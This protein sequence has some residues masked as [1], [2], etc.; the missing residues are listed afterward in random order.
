LERFSVWKS[1][2]TQ[3]GI[4]ERREFIKAAGAATAVLIAAGCSEGKKD[5]AEAPAVATRITD[6]LFTYIE[7]HHPWS[8]GGSCTIQVLRG[9]KKTVIVDTGEFAGDFRNK[10]LPAMERDGMKIS[11]VGEI[12]HTHGHA[13]HIA[14]DQF[15]QSAC[16]AR[17][18][19]HP[20]AVHILENPKSESDDALKELGD[21]CS[22]VMKMSPAVL[23]FVSGLMIGHKQRITIAGVF[24]DGQV[25]DV[26]FPV[27]VKFVRGHSLHSVAFYAPTRRLIFTGDT[28][29]TG[30]NC[31]PMLNT[32]EADVEE[33]RTTV[34]WMIGKS[35]AILANGHYGTVVGQRKCEETLR[36]CLGFLDKIKSS[37]LQVLCRGPAS[38]D[39]FYAAYNQDDQG[40]NQWEAGIANWCL[41][42]S[43]TRQ[44]KVVRVP[45][46]DGKK[47]VDLKWKIT[48]S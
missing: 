37:A 43:L 17:I 16:N 29:E 23:R 5:K 25:L 13:D 21:D 30:V 10:V 3:G 45:K 18:Y 32:P 14:A 47:L 7:P 22:P 11:D 19:V 9:P 6:E 39:D 35:P 40:R 4:M 36:Q 12:W 24:T 46:Y 27:E 33:M 38:L 2:Q 1:A 34:E 48:A 31:R 42:K 20:N 41:M 15:I 8:L 28:V 26:G 44:G